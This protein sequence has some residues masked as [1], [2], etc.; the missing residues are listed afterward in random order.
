LATLLWVSFIQ[1]SRYRDVYVTIQ[2][3][4]RHCL[5][6]QLGVKVDELGILRCYGRYLYADIP[7]DVKCPKL[8]PR[9]EYFTELVPTFG[10]CRCFTYPKSSTTRIPKDELK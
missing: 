1:H 7:E 9:R 4:K 5:Q 2:N 3:K 10:A 6:I 8:L